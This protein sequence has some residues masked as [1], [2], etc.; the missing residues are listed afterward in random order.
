MWI[1]FVIGKMKE[2]DC[3]SQ[4]RGESKR[5]LWG[6][7]GAGRERKT[8][9]RAVNSRYPINIIALAPHIFSGTYGLCPQ[10]VEQ[11]TE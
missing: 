1:T 6:N 2:G 4:E 5:T 9:Y 8:S 3:V 7:L 10:F 11:W